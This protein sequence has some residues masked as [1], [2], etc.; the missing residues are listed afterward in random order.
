MPIAAKILV[1]N[2]KGWVGNVPVGVHFHN[3]YGLA[4]ANTLMAVEA[5]AE[6][7]D[8]VINGLGDRA[9][10]AALEE[11]VMALTILYGVKTDICIDK[12]FKASK[13]TQE[14]TNVKVQPNKPIVGENAFVHESDSHIYAIL[15]QGPFT[16]ENFKPEIV[17]HKRE[18][19]FGLTT[20][21]GPAIE[22]LA[23]NIGIKLNGAALK[24]V[25]QRVREISTQN[26]E[27]VTDND[28]VKIIREVTEK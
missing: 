28:L 22:A 12:L 25:I 19:R 6:A 15:K 20:L 16:Y 26:I 3:D 13:I 18:I 4:V 7:A 17:G 24:T 27:Y 23:E 1:R 11:T 21:H 10:N 14:I 2:V 9:G 8:L 5:G